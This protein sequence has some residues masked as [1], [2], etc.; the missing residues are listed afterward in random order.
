[1][2]EHI[3]QAKHNEK[4]LLLIEQHC[5]DNYF[6]W[7]I[8]VVF[9][10]ALHYL[11]AFESFKKIKVGGTHKDMIYHIN[12]KN[13]DAKMKI[14]QSC[15]DCYIDLF[16]MAHTSRYNGIKD[17]KVYLQLLKYNLSLAKKHLDHIKK[18][19]EGHGLK[20]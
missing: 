9:Y 5:P 10:C 1:M 7:K 4:F 17:T 19:V 15:A 8:T 6:D 18:F 13:K 20:I 3:N 12:P 16:N 2:T 14:D 11:R